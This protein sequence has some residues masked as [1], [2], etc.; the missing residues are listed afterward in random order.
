MKC[1]DT[2]LSLSDLLG[3]RDLEVVYRI[4]SND[5]LGNRTTDCE[6][7]KIGKPV[8]NHYLDI[9]QGAWMRDPVTKENITVEKIWLTKEAEPY[10]VY[11]YKN[12]LDYQKDIKAKLTPYKLSCPAQV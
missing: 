5:T 1:K 6:L 7:T 3:N 10:N 2:S 12:R 8:L 4:G 11:E 9:A